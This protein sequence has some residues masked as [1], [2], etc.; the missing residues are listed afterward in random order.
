MAI[1]RPCLSS[2]IQLDLIDITPAPILARLERF[3]DGVFGVMEMLGRVLILRRI[4]AANMAAFQ[5]QAEMNPHVPAFQ[6]FLA[7]FRRARFYV[8]YVVKMRT[9]IH[10]FILQLSIQDK[11]AGAY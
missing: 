4:A 3:H 2:K 7:A 5:A 10:F 8:V 1:G 9:G 6:A 11:R